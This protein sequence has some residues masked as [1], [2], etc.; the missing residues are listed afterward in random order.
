MRRLAVF[1]VLLWPLFSLGQ[2][3]MYVEIQSTNDNPGYNEK[4]KL[5]Y[6]LKIKNTGGSVSI[7]HNGVQVAPPNIGSFVKVDE[8]A[9][10]P[11]MTFGSMGGDM[12]IHAYDVILQ[13]TKQGKEVIGPVTFLINN[14]KIVSESMTINVGGKVNVPSKAATSDMFVTTEV[15]K[16]EVYVGEPLTISF[17]I[18]LKRGEFAKTEELSFP[19]FSGFWSEEYELETDWQRKNINGVNYEVVEVKRNILFPRKAGEIVIDPFT[20]SGVF[21]TREGRGLFGQRKQHTWSDSSSKRTIKVKELPNGKP[22]NFLGTF[23]GLTL[24]VK[25][26]PEELEVNKAITLT[27]KFTG[28][29]NLK[30]LQDVQFDFPDEF[31]VYDPKMTNNFKTNRSNVS[32]SR[33]AEYVILTRKTGKFLIEGQSFSYFDYAQEK[34]VNL[35]IQDLEFNILKGDG[36][37]S[38]NFSF[39]GR[40]QVNVLNQ[41]VRFI[42]TDPDSITAKSSRFFG[43][44]PYYGL[45]SLPVLGFFALLFFIRRRDTMQGDVEG[46]KKKRAG[47]MVA[48]H[49]K[50]A[51]EMSNAN[52]EEQFYQE[53]SG[54][55]YGYISDKYSLKTKDMS[56]ENISEVLT[57]RMDDSIKDELIFVLAKCDEARYAPMKSGSMQELLNRSKDIIGSIE[58]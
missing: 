21:V 5:T 51:E 46:Y 24:N 38:G 37:N 53:L 25:A 43:T 20:F 6:T 36:S 52:N 32:G 40:T 41:D 30:L 8:S 29:G 4:F 58:K 28:S 57:G 48:K 3:K 47:K 31:E 56:Y 9:Y 12:A 26:T 22:A 7:S 10:S 45:A 15:N 16:S 50:T 39:D 19:D 18:Y 14:E 35:N 1:I 17:K 49:L 42:K 11:R 2:A 23:K 34:Y 54:A 13:P 44:V 55:M 27:S 33:T